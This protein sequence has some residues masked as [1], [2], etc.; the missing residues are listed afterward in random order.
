MHSLTAAPSSSKDEILL[1]TLALPAQTGV[2]RLPETY[3]EDDNYD[4]EEEIL[5]VED[6]DEDS[7]QSSDETADDW[8]PKRESG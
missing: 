2:E 1:S 7:S 5:A 3:S 6:L 4:N 8:L